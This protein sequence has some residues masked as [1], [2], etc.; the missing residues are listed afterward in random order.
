MPI[1]S[2]AAQRRVKMERVSL[3]KGAR[4]TWHVDVVLGDEDIDRPGVLHF[5]ITGTLLGVL[6]H[7][8]R[9]L[10]ADIASKEYP[11]SS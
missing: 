1:V 9:G 3:G 10:R 4:E 11:K 7:D 8:H 6:S 2:N 5:K